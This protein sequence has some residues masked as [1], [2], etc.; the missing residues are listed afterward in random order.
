VCAD[1]EAEEH[2][3]KAAHFI[4]DGRSMHEALK[5]WHNYFVQN[6]T[7]RGDFTWDTEERLTAEERRCIGKSIAAF[8]LGE[9]SEGKGLLKAADSFAK[10]KNNP[11]LSP[12]TKLFIAEEQ[13]HALLLR[14]FMELNGIA[15]MKHNWTDSIFRRLRK[16]VGFELSITVLITAEIISLVYY[17]ALK[18][19]TKSNLLKNICGKVL[20]D[21]RAHVKYESELLGLIRPTNSAFRRVLLPFLHRV[22]LV[23]TVLVVYLSHR[24]V[25]NRGRYDL[26]NFIAACWL[27]FSNC[28]PSALVVRASA[29][30]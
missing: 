20:A 28:F 27:E 26:P 17:D 2:Y 22:L 23:G 15:L 10:S 24:K 14:K 11:Y 7:N 25:L 29:S 5:D 21:E 30:A 6:S 19:A 3:L 8:Q 12:I 16:N 1:Q 4:L 9:H 13:N 18:N